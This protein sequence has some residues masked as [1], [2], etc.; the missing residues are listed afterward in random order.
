M[1]E[2]GFSKHNWVKSD[3]R[4]HL[5][6]EILDGLI[7]M[8]LCSLPIENMDWTRSF[9]TWKSTQNRRALPLKLDDD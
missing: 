2:R 5:K 9:D 7:Q 6:L 1:C 8:S 3:C 4:N